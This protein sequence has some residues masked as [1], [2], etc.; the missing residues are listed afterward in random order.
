MS[1]SPT[2]P[3]GYT[4]AV[5]DLTQCCCKKAAMTR[6]TEVALCCTSKA[7]ITLAP[8]SPTVTST[9][10]YHTQGWRW[11]GRPVFLPCDCLLVKARRYGQLR[12][13][14]FLHTHTQAHRHTGTRACTGTLKCARTCA[15]TRTVLGSIGLN[16]SQ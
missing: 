8:V 2:V 4:V 7:S 9:A 10:L 16:K 1:L 5:L 14:F 6:C 13:N 15:C 3:P 11:S 12:Y